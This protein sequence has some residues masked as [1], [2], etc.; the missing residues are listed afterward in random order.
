MNK[1]NFLSEDGISMSFIKRLPLLRAGLC[2]ALRNSDQLISVERINLKIR[3]LPE[4]AM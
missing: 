2:F 1:L 4:S 3:L